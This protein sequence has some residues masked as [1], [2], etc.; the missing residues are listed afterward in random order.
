MNRECVGFVIGELTFSS[1]GICQIILMVVDLFEM[2]KKLKISSE[3]KFMHFCPFCRAH[4]M[5][6]WKTYIVRKQLCKVSRFCERVHINA[7]QRRTLLAGFAMISRCNTS[8]NV[9]AAQLSNNLGSAMYN[10]IRRSVGWTV[11]FKLFCYQ[12]EFIQVWKSTLINTC[13]CNSINFL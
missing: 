8:F 9:Q 3:K 6:L 4:L 13:F 10:K 2:K 7:S 5:L 1:I 12:H 11:S